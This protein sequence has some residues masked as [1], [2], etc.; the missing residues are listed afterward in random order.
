MNRGPLTVRSALRLVACDAEQAQHLDAM[1][2]KKRR[3]HRKLVP[4]VQEHSNLLPGSQMILAR[5]APLAAARLVELASNGTGETA[6]KACLDIISTHN[7]FT[8]QQ[9][10]AEQSA[11][12]SD[13]LPEL[14]DETA[15]KLL[16]ILAEDK[17]KT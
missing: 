16:A 3:T 14:S 15:S 13:S 5:Y 1:L 4:G 2:S 11:A 8:H 9:S 12:D 7:Y 10:S 17:V 6:R